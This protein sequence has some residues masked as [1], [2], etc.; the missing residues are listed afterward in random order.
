MRRRKFI[1]LLSG[2]AVW[3]LAAGAQQGERV[4]R[5]A[6]FPTGAEGDRE[7]QNYVR[8]LRQGLEKLGWSD[9]RNIQIDVRWESGDPAR[10][11]ADV[12]TALSLAPEVIVS[13]G[14]QTTSE[15]ERRTRSIPIIFVNVGDPLASNLVQ[16]LARP[17]GN[18]TGF[19]AIESSFGGKW[20][21]LLKEIA[22]RVERLLVLFNPQ[23]PTW[24]FHVPT[25][26][27]AA[28][29]LA[30]PVTTLPV[31]SSGDIES[32]IIAFASK[33]NGGLIMLPSAFAQAHREEIVALAAKY[34][35]PAMYAV[36]TYVTSGG[37]ISYGSDWVDQYRQAAMYVDRIL[38]GEK[39]ADLPVQAPTKFELVINLKTAKALGLEVPLHLQ[40]L[41][42]E[43]IE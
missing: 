21:E 7:A 5:I 19:T 4:R 25:I 9:G 24:K 22:P 37:L 8:A 26:E 28:S 36:R 17:G 14:T 13:G 38:K 12:E 3:P 33:P 39:P 35:L 15:L 34:Q 41:A 32:A 43:L 23:N 2:A 16:S 10:M 31:N 11:L 1:F 20:I 42:D 29:K 6:L 40:Q 18:F 27:A 30:L